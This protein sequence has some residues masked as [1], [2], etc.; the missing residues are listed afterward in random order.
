MSQNPPNDNSLKGT[1]IGLWEWFSFRNY[2][3]EDTFTARLRSYKTVSFLFFFLTSFLNFLAD[4]YYSF[5]ITSVFTVLIVIVGHL[6]DWGKTRSAYVLL[7]T[8]FISSLLLLSNFE[9]LRAGAYFFFFP[10]IVSFA[11]LADYIDRKTTVTTYIISLA[12]LL[13]CLYISPEYSKVQKMTENMY[14]I[15]FRFNVITSFALILW[16]SFAL[17]RENQLRLNTLK[18]NERYLN[19]IFNTSLNATL[20]IDMETGLVT[21][22]NSHS[23]LLFGA[24]E[25][26]NPIKGSE[27][28]SFFH[29]LTQDGWE[30]LYQEMCNPHKN[31]EGELTCIRKD[32]TFFPAVVR[33]AS[34]RYNDKEYKKITIDDISERKEILKE[35]REAKSK[36][37]ESAVVKTQFL[38]NMSHELRTPLN[39]IIGATNLLLLE[40]TLPSQQEQLNI[41]KF[42][43]EHMLSLI[44]EILDLSKL[45]ANKVKLEKITIDIPGFIET[46]S[47]PFLNQF[48]DKGLDFEVKIDPLIKTSVTGDPTRI[49]QV[50]GNLLSNALKFTSNGGVTLEVKALAVKSESMHLEF[51]V[52][53]TGIGIS[54]E[55]R[56]K[57]F[58]QFIQADE[59]TTRKYGG[60]GLGLTISQKL[61]QLMNG[62]LKVES[63]Y[64]KG[65]KFYFDVTLPIFRSRTRLFVNTKAPQDT[66]ALKGLKVLI[67][68]DNPIN[69]MIASRFLDKWGIVYSKAVNGLEAVSLCTQKDFDLILMD[70]EMPEMDG[71]GALNEIRKVNEKIPAIAF[72]AAVFENMREKLTASGFNDY[73]QKPFQPDDLHARLVKFSRDFPKA[74]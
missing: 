52:T 7:L 32:G 59:K 3:N 14:T 12:A 60:T 11:F 27:A 28:C 15:N 20:V 10:C 69:M 54:E 9:G 8:I 26:T 2:L 36:A 53:D 23:I 44:N 48:R 68:E 24:G 74:V 33:I 25:E 16:M 63:K 22:H 66:T 41:L 38:S 31:W 45:D 51:S 34:F 57:I 40:Q 29:E 46:V 73:I 42:S 62:E 56:Q 19:T 55:K 71:Y 4:L 1:I 50:L 37:E 39:G 13:I 58:E 43:S 18:N 72:T 35:L 30:D 17:A 21:N 70:L 49:N 65:S 64:N 5:A 6:I 61:V 67:A 47:V